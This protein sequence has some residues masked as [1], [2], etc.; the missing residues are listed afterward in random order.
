MAYN[1]DKYKKIFES[2]HGKG[3]FDAGLASARETGKLKAQG[4]FAKTQYI[5]AMKKAQK[6]AEKRAEEEALYGGQSK[7]SYE[8]TMKEVG[9]TTAKQEKAQKQGRGGHMPDEKQLKKEKAIQSEYKRTGVFPSNVQKMIDNLDFSDADKKNAEY[10]AKLAK[11]KEKKKEKGLLERLGSAVKDTGKDILEGAQDAFQINVLKRDR[12]KVLEDTFKEYAKKKQ[13]PSK[14]TEEIARGSTRFMNSTTLGAIKEGAKDADN[15]SMQSFFNEREGK[16]KAADIAYDIAGYLVPGAGAY[17]AVRGAGLGVKAGAKGLDKVA[18]LAKEGAIAGGVIGAGEVGV[19]EGLNPEDYTAQNNADHIALGAALGAVADPA[20]YGLA[21]GASKVVSK[22][23]QGNVPEYT[24]RPS[25]STLDRLTPRSSSPGTNF[26]SDNLFDRLSR[27]GLTPPRNSMTPEASAQFNAKNEFDEAVE[28]QFQYLKESLNNRKGV[29]QGNVIRDELGD[30]VSKYGRISE[31]PQWYSEFYNQ[32][33]K[34][35]N[36]QE[37]RALAEKHVRE[38]FSDEFGDVPAWKPSEPTTPEVE[39]INSQIDELETMAYQNPGEESAIRPL[40]E[41]LEQEKSMLISQPPKNTPA[42]PSLRERVAPIQNNQVA[43][44]RAPLEYENISS[45]GADPGLRQVNPTLADE[46]IQTTGNADSFRSK[47]DRNSAKKENNFFSTLR[48]QFIDDVAPLENLEKQITGKVASAENSLY[49]QARLYKGS[50]EKAHLIVQEQLTPIINEVQKSGNNIQ[51]LGDYALAVHA[52]DVNAKGI[53]S[54]FTNAEIDDVI[55]RLGSESMEAARK[56]LVKVNDD[57]LRMLSTGDSPVLNPSDVDAMRAKWP[58]YMSLFRSFDDDKIEFASGLSKALSVG[59]SPIKKLEGSSRNVIDPIESVVKNIFK[60]TSVA[61]RNKVA[62]QLSK[63]AEVDT[64]GLVRRLPDGEDTG[65]MNVISA[66]ENGKRV[67]YEVPPDVYKAMVNLDKESSNTLIRILQKPASTLRAGATLT[68]EFSLRNPLRD[69]PNA[70]VVS[71]SGF[72][73]VIDFPVG[74]WQ[75]IWKG[76]TIKIGGKEFKTSGDLYKQF[77][78]EN[79]GYGNIVSMDRELHQQTLKKALTDSSTQYVDVLNPQVYKSLMKKFSNPLNALR[80]VAD[81]S[82]TATKVGEFRAALRSGT[83][84]QEAGY[85]AR[86]IMDFARA[87]VSVREANKV[88]AFLN[89]NMQGKSKLWRAFKENPAKVGGKAIASVTIPT[90]GAIVA[91]N[92]Y[93][94]ER[95]KEILNDAPQWLK[96]TFYLVPIPGTNQIARIPK[97]FDLAFMFSNPLERAF[98]FV[99]KNDKEAFDGFMKQA[100]SAMAVPTM[101]TGV[102]PIV[103]GMANYSF[104]RQGPIIPQ[105]EENL[106]YPDQYDINTT[107]TG[108]FIGSQINKVTGGKGAFRNFGSPRVIDN[109]IQGFTGGLGTYATSSIDWFLNE[110][111][112]IDKPEKPAKGIDQLPVAKAFLVN[113]NTSGKSLEKL[114]NLKEKLTDARGSAKQNGQ[115]FKDEQKYNVANRLTKGLAGLNKQIRTVENSPEL[116][117]EEKKVQLEML[118][119]Q[120]NEAARKA[121]ETLNNM[122]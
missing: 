20:L 8:A 52:K 122:E 7:K 12:N 91:Q 67:K 27:N 85:R 3:S 120:R 17:K 92:T 115:V 69:V 40:I 104:F 72:N 107:E 116:S 26:Q 118:I 97:P 58:N 47:I 94:N 109:T 89:A 87:G 117:G 75:S 11:E 14:V 57:V 37:L 63:L 10:N 64:D 54:G 111:N 82:E 110:T 41:A 121:M 32:N 33:G 81:V 61:D 93:A 19:R 119:R 101:L 15:E 1:A 18:Q 86:D 102:A 76:R 44:S 34:V 22:S 16:G 51:D 73:P 2:R 35:P 45:G 42:G 100:F 23:L 84:P 4:E 103:E 79:G 99:A 95:Q 9:K 62:S 70:F 98:D 55:N 5:A 106:N 112:A 21:K 13:K 90:I 83:S 24:G 71:N 36:N 59:S 56:N 96:D 88:V 108:K 39:N 113:Q 66:M 65:R 80:N 38:G 78:K 50:P 114:Y 31:N 29:Q 53:N 25:E 49:K 43:A 74:L 6:E 60:A 105:R 77:I 30:V 28:N 46:T 48:T 68:P